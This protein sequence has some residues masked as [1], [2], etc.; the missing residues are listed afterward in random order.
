MDS[1]A[2]QPDREPPPPRP[3]FAAGPDFEGTIETT[4]EERAWLAALHDD[5]PVW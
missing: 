1:A 4:N 3:V 5:E 2:P